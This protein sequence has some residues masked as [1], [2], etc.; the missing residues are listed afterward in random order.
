MAEP[1]TRRT[2]LRSVGTVAA[3]TAAARTRAAE[4]YRTGLESYSFHDVDLATTLA[5]TKE[6]G[7]HYIELHDG[8][9]P[10][11]SPPA[12]LARAKQ[13]FKRAGITPSGV[14]IHDA[15]TDSEA[16]ARPIFE[17][18]RT[19]GFGYINGQ[20]K[21]ESL[22]LLDTLSPEYGVRIAIHNHGPG[23]R[24]Q[25]LADVTSVLER[26]PKLVSCVDIGHF[27]RSHVDPVHAIRTI[28]RRMIAVH[29]KDV[30]AAGENV[31]LGEGTID[32]PG[33]FAA[34]ADLHFTGLVVLEYEGDFDD[35]AARLEGMR[36]S[37]VVMRKMI[38]DSLK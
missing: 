32:L 19:M 21:P 36:Q 6:L 16:V 28:G 3:M 18:A 4:P 38:G 24:Y 2:F 34:L 20:P 26:Y 12:D 27:A 8:H 29:I 11:T 31:V 10:Y 25:T 14:Y 7:L 13:A 1:L 30:D 22:A 37:L 33:V 9:V 17:Y 35:M 5:R 15:F 23:M